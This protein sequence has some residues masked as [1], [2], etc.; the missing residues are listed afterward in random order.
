MKT[1]YNSNS[2]PMGITVRENHACMIF[3]A[4]MPMEGAPEYEQRSGESRGEHVSAALREARVNCGNTGSE[5]APE[6]EQR[7]GD[8]RGEHASAALREA[9]VNCGNI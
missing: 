4:D 5:G 3:Q 7:G 8:S 9:R 2:S 6:Y 1:V